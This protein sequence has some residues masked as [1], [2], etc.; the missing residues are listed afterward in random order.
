M[1]RLI[2]VVKEEKLRVPHHKEKSARTGIS[3]SWKIDANYIQKDRD[4]KFEVYESGQY[5]GE[6][7]IKQGRQSKG[8]E[9]CG[10]L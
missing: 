2:T 5:C 1:A 4:N 10:S 7:L 9:G 3:S 6:T 8:S